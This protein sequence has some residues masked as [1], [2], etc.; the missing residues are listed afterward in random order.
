MAHNGRAE[1]Q[2]ALSARAAPAH[3]RCGETRAELFAAAFGQA[4][5]NGKVFLPSLQVLHPALVIS[6][7]AGLRP[8]LFSDLALAFGMLGQTVGHLL[9]VTFKQ[10]RFLGLEPHLRGRGAF[11]VDQVGNLGQVLLGVIPTWGHSRSWGY[12]P[13]GIVGVILVVV[14]ILLVMGRL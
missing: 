5:A 8:Q 2:Q 1:W 7:V 3:P 6:K 4:A 14:V 9:S 13:S 10:Y 12:G 11:T